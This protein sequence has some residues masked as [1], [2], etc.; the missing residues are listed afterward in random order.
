MT[1]LSLLATLAFVSCLCAAPLQASVYN[2]V[3]FSDYVDRTAADFPFAP[4]AFI[5]VGASVSGG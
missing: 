1:R 4:V 2:S 3:I 5:Q